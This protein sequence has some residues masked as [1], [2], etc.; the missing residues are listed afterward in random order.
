MKSKQ[1][2]AILLLVGLT[3]IFAPALL[4]QAPAGREYVVQA[5]DWLSKIAE[6]EYGDVL[7]YPTIVEATNAK[8]AE[9]AS[10]AAI[11]NPDVIEIGQKL[12]LPAGVDGA[13][14]APAAEPAPVT[15]ITATQV[16]TFIPATIP[17]E[18]QSGSCWTGSVA[19]SRADAY[20]CTVDN[21]IYDPCFVV[22]DAPTVICDAD[23]STGS[24][25][26]VLALT[27]PL[28]AQEIVVA[29]APWLIELADG[30]VCGVMTGT[31]PVIGDRAAS[32]GCPDQSYLFE[33]LQ[34]GEVWLAE[35]AVISL[36]DAGF[37]VESSE[38]VP[39]KTVWQ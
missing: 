33:D 39:L 31:R 2:L 1:I 21:M 14:T 7:A 10:F 35:K 12:W 19:V 6:K 8:A 16:I 15:D 36:N 17:T 27:E 25:G 37:S 29:P 32:Y 11:A 22:D 4:A 26:F 5:D 23:P 9:D 30:Q 34:P 38:M 3:L 28:P 24:T 18:T 20:R 13:E